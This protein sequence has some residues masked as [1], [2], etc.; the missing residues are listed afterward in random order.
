MEIENTIFFFCYDT[1][2]NV[3][4]S[5][6][7]IVALPNNNDTY[8]NIRKKTWLINNIQWLEY[9]NYLVYDGFQNVAGMDG[10]WL[11]RRE[12]H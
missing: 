2:K 9:S 5:I 7:R 10:K 11:N 12:S 8:F 4:A 3:V 6:K 1:I